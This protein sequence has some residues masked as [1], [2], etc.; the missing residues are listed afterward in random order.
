MKIDPG[1]AEFYASAKAN[2]VPVVIVSR[3]VGDKHARLNRRKFLIVKN[4][5]A[6]WPL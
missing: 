2:A 3:L 4:P 6:E 1:F 5:T